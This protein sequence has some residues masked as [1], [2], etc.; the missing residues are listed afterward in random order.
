MRWGGI[1]PC[2][3]IEIREQRT[4]NRGQRTEKS[5]SGFASEAVASAMV[6]I[7]AWFWRGFA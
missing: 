6:V 2:N 5:G 4:E 3:G 1:I 7:L